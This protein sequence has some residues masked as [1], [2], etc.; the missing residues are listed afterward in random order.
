MPHSGHALLSAVISFILLGGTTGCLFET[1][2]LAY[3]A[4]LG[5]DDCDPGWGEKRDAL[6]CFLP[7]SGR[8]YCTPECEQ[9]ADCPAGGPGNDT[10]RQCKDVPVTNGDK[11]AKVCVISCDVGCP[12]G[13]E[14]QADGQYLAG[15]CLFPDR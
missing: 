6:G 7:E 12:E 10:P 13:M 5:A 15:Y 3:S 1:D 11:H 14:C 4:C 8:G 2:F 9:D